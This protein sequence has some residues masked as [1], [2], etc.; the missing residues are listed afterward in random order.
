M[1]VMGLWVMFINCCIFGRSF[2]R[3]AFGGGCI[4]LIGFLRNESSLGS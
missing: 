3:A 2:E 4:S 1:E